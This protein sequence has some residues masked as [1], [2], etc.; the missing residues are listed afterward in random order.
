MSMVFLALG[1]VLIVEG[2][3]IALAPSRMDQIIALLAQLG[4]DRRRAI[5]LAMLALGILLVWLTRASLGA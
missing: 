2:L 1:L 3:A 4:R 5:G